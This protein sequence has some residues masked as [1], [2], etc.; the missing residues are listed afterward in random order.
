MDVAGEVA[1]ARP[2]DGL[3]P[4]EEDPVAH[5][6]EVDEGDEEAPAEVVGTEDDALVG[7][8]E[9]QPEVEDGR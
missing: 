2:H 8:E 5:D 6:L 7:Q 1:R 4:E 3:V 9:E